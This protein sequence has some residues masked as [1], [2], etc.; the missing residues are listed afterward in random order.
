[1]GSHRDYPVERLL[2]MIKAVFEEKGLQR[3]TVRDLLSQ[4]MAHESADVLFET[5]GRVLRNAYSQHGYEAGGRY[6]QMARSLA[7]TAATLTQLGKELPLKR[8]AMLMLAG[9]AKTMTIGVFRYSLLA[10]PT[11]IAE[12]FEVIRDSRRERR[13]IELEVR[14]PLLPSTALVNSCLM[15]FTPVAN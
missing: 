11:A 8:V 3:R 14:E 7:P 15:L 4:K 6:A 2:P 5:L 9:I 13:E 10:I 12:R 1:M